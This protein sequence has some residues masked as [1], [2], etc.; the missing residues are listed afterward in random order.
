MWRGDS[1]EIFYTDHDAIYSISVS[2]ENGIVF[3]FPIF[4]RHI[5]DFFSRQ[6][7]QLVRYGPVAVIVTTW[8]RPF[9]R[10]ITRTRVPKGRLRWAAVFLP[11]DRGMPLAVVRP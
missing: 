6:P 7:R 3:G 5:V 10:L 1:K 11:S 2:D 8:S 4:R 9:F